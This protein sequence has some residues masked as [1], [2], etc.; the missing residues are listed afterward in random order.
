[1]VGLCVKYNKLSGNILSHEITCL[2]SNDIMY[3]NNSP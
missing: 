3:L 2:L 1:M